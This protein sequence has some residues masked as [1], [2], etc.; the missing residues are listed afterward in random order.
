MQFT[1]VNTRKFKQGILKFYN[2]KKLRQTLYWYFFNYDWCFLSL[3]YDLIEL[4][5]RRIRIM[6]E[7]NKRLEESIKQ[8]EESTER[9]KEST[10]QLE[11]STDRLKESTKR[12]E[13][14]IKQLEI[15]IRFILIL[16]FVMVACVVVM[17]ILSI[18]ASPS[19]GT[20]SDS[21]SS[22][23]IV[24]YYDDANVSSMFMEY[25][26]EANNFTK[27]PCRVIIIFTSGNR[28]ESKFSVYTRTTQQYYIVPNYRKARASYDKNNKSWS[29]K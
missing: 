4:Q 18:A 2:I 24:T 14:S 5:I 29:L 26:D 22:L 23:V 27:R 11:E 1:K 7:D 25:F 8:L 13:E 20:T 9:L 17:T 16:T 10:N 28:S 3:G 6:E 19:R 12:L 15:K 21:Y